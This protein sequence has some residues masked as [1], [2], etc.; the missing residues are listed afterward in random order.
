MAYAIQE[1]CRKAGVDPKKVKS[2][3]NR[4][5]KLGK[6]AEKMGLH[7]FG[8]SG[9]G[10]LRT[11]DCGNGRSIIVARICAGHWD[12]GDGEEYELDGIWYGE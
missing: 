9:N 10:T 8:G 4:L 7:I 11:S 6:E 1:S 3:A 12:G 2:I 5:E